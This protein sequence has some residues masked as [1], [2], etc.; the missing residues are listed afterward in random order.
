MD[1]TASMN[2]TL[3]CTMVEV[4]WS[5]SSITIKLQGDKNS[6]EDCY[7]WLAVFQALWVIGPLPGSI[8]G[9]LMD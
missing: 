7:Q 8:C 6:Q 2:L 5:V 9:W 4:F 3:T 1:N